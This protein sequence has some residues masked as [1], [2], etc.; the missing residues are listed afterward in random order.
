MLAEK[1]FRRAAT[2]TYLIMDPEKLPRLRAVTRRTF[3]F[4]VLAV[5]SLPA[6]LRGNTCE[7]YGFLG[8]D[9]SVDP[10]TGGCCEGAQCVSSCTHLVGA[11]HPGVSCWTTVNYVTCCDCFDLST[12]QPCGCSSHGD[13]PLR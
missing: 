1:I 10:C 4:L 13:I 9:C 2:G 8:D 7:E 5:F 12:E 6:A 11:C 3:S